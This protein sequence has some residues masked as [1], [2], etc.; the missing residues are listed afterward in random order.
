MVF[1]FSFFTSEQL[2]YDKKVLGYGKFSF[3]EF[4]ILSLFLKGNM[5]EKKE[6]LSYAL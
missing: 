1:H 5:D 4:N 2:L 6:W 3:K